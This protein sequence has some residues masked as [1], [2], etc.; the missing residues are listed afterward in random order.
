M[1]LRELV[2]MTAGLLKR[3]MA[4]DE[5]LTVPSIVDDKDALAEIARQHPSAC[6]GRT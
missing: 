3:E 5:A 1:R 6:A 2:N 4:L